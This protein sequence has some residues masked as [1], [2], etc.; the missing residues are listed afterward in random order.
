MKNI[1]YIIV[2]FFIGTVFGQEPDALFKKATQAYN[3]GN[4][5]IAIENYKQILEQDQ[6]SAALYYNLANAHY[7][8]N[9]V[10]PSIYYYEKALQLQPNDEDIKNNLVFAENMKIDAIED[11][12]KT[13]LAKMINNLISTYTFNTWAWL[14]II[15]SV[16]FVSLFLAY[17]FSQRTGKKRIFFSLSV[18]SIVFCIVSVVFA[19]QQYNIQQ[20]NQ[21][22]I[23]F[24]EEIGVQTEPNDRAEKTFMLHEGTKVGILEDFS[25]FIKIELADGTQGWVKKEA[26]KKL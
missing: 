10:A 19:F 12:P 24:E 4:Y 23:I 7:K 8:L 1:V 21:F 2:F 26:L 16:G 22:G 14:A 3:D 13:G 25:G 18:L 15:F 9:H 5:E 6:V 17:Y 11:V 20:N